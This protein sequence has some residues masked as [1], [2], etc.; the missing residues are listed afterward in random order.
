MRS[1]TLELVLPIGSSFWFKGW[2]PS[3]CFV[4]WIHLCLGILGKLKGLCACLASKGLLYC[5]DYRQAQGSE[6]ILY[7]ALRDVLSHVYFSIRVLFCSMLTLAL[8][9]LLGYVNLLALR[10]CPI[11]LIFQTLLCSLTPD[12]TL[13]VCIKASGE[14]CICAVCLSVLFDVTPA[15]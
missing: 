4:A 6:K 10:G 2:T 12:M 15:P 14:L 9:E 5:I 3:H 8:S 13:L 7:L 11:D 1:V